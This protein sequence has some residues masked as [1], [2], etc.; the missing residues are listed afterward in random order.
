[1]SFLGPVIAI[2]RVSAREILRGR[3]LYGAFVVCLAILSVG[4]LAAKLSFISPDRMMIDFGVTA[5]SL[6][7][8]AVGVLFGSSLIAKEMERKT[9]FVV[10]SRPVSRAQFLLGQY[11]G[12]F[13]VIALNAV[14]LS[15]AFVLVLGM[16]QGSILTALYPQLGIALF[17]AFVEAIFLGAVTVFFSTFSTP[18]LSSMLAVGVYLVG[19]NASEFKQALLQSGAGWIRWAVMFLPQLEYFHLGTKVYYRIPISFQYVVT[20]V[21]YGGVL[22]VFFLWLSCFTIRSRE[23]Q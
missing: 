18:T 7:S 20:A 11:L 5:V 3:I 10:L 2:A 8:S 14:I 22:T 4:F 6:C 23:I 19:T 17:L 16:A 1:M 15:L 9:W 12:L 13:G 21:A